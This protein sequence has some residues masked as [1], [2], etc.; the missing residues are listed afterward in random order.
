VRRSTGH[1]IYVA[2]L[3]PIPVEIDVRP[4]HA[5]NRFHPRSRRPIRVAILG[6]ETFDVEG[7][8]L[9]TVGFGPHAARPV[10]RAKIRDV[11]HDGWSDV[12]LRFWPR[13]GRIASDATEVC[14][15]GRTSDGVKFE[16]CDT[17]RMTG[18]RTSFSQ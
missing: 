4:G 17:I 5:S 1:S 7:V 9:E 15:S 16:G 12:L 6:S 13:D 3:P 18:L 11:N 10:R 14:L 2:E 8:D